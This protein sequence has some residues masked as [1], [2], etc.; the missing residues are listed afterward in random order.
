MESDWNR[1]FAQLI[2][3]CHR[4]H[5]KRTATQVFTISPSPKRSN[6]YCPP[7]CSLSGSPV[8]LARQ[9]TLFIVLALIIGKQCRRSE[10][11][12]FA[13]N[14]QAFAR[15]SARANKPQPANVHDSFFLAT[16]IQPLLQSASDKHE[17]HF[18]SERFSLFYGVLLQKKIYDVKSRKKSSVFTEEKRASDGCLV[19]NNK[20]LLRALSNGR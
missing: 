5:G 17:T 10:G 1:T 3:R 14:K 12:H 11:G 13:S 19:T 9:K 4:G 20:R 7:L 18:R 6:A 16:N 2:A 8:T 15:R